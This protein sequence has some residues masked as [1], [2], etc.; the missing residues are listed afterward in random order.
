MFQNNHFSLFLLFFAIINLIKNKALSKVYIYYSTRHQCIIPVCWL[1]PNSNQ[2]ILF[3][4]FLVE[5]RPAGL[6]HHQ[7]WLVKGK[8]SANSNCDHLM[9]CTTLHGSIVVRATFDRNAKPLY[10]AS[11]PAL[12]E[13]TGYLIIIYLR[14]LHSLSNI[15]PNLAVIRGEKQVVHYS[16]VI[17]NTLL[18][19][20]ILPSLTVI[21]S[22][23]VRIDHNDQMCYV[24]TIRWRSI[25]L[26]RALTEENFGI[27]FYKN[28]ENCYNK[29][30]IGHCY[31][32]S[33]HHSA[34]Q[35]HCFG[36]GNTDNA[37][38]QKCKWIPIIFLFNMILYYP[39]IV[40]KASTLFQ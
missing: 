22:G 17:Y 15:F 36:P 10:D 3:Y 12:R 26:E 9:N 24:D 19:K 34:R 32:P 16:L 39:F 2:L 37:E 28:N 20:V 18:E 11:F 13:I 33:G 8:C 4:L 25:V 35:Q 14:D 1:A 38:C 40:T 29:C 5:C 6:F 31:A 30:L 7:L 23:G 27:A 21:K